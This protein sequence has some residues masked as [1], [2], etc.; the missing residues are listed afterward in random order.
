MKAVAEFPPTPTSVAGAR[1]FVAGLLREA[2]TEVVETVT[3]MVSELATNCV[4][5]AK[6]PYRIQVTVDGS[7]IRVEVTDHSSA[8]ATARSPGPFESHGRGLQ[9]VRGLADQ[10]GVIERPA[11]PGKTAWFTLDPRTR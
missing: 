8:R 10:W 6:T 7:T 4:R 5:H 3:L 2:P 1:T 11:L 9:I